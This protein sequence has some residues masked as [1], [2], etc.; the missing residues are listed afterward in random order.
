MSYMLP[1]LKS[2]WHVD[3]AILSE[4]ERIVVMRF[5]RDNDEEC[6]RQ[7]EVLYKIADKVKNFA[8]IYRTYI[9]DSALQTPQP[10]ILSSRG[11]D[12]RGRYE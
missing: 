7:D 4:E 3:Q 11:P 6:M 12:S 9:L 10:H 1:H 2:G 5:G 8:V